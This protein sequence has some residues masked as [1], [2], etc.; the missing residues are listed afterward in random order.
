MKPPL[1]E[2]PIPFITLPNWVKAAARCGFNIQPIFKE[3]GIPTDLVHLENATVPRL[4]LVKAMRICV[5]QSR[6]HHFPFVL[7]ETFAFE[8]LT[9]LE[10][11]LTTSPTLREAAKIFEWVRELINPMINVELT[12]HGKDA[13]LILRTPGEDDS[14]QAREAARWFTETTFAAI[15]RFGRLLMGEHGDYRELQ[16]KGAAPR[17]AAEY[18]RYFKLLVRFNARDDALVM[19]RAL[20]DVPLKGAFPSL[21]EQAQFRVEQRLQK[22]PSRT[23]L[24][25]AIEDALQ[26][27]LSLLGQGVEAVAAELKLHPRTLQRR[28]RDT[29]DQFADLQDR[30]RYRLAMQWL[31]DPRESLEDISERLGFSDRRS[32]T[33]AFSRWSGA[34]PSQFRLRGKK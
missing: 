30:V 17:Y 18:R 27:K 14:P 4:Q 7:G 8:Y 32:F 34:T 1:H 15:V 21:H 2:D 22:M 3:L 33:R 6:Q 11:F 9:D 28:L 29:G 31:D 24:V 20:M 25:A 5:A 23:G 26:K 10:T 19:D 13:R 12:E 16:M